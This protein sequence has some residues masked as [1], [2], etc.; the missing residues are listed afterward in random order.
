MRQT[1]GV[2]HYHQEGDVKKGDGPAP[3]PD[4]A[5]RLG[6]PERGILANSDHIAFVCVRAESTTNN[7]GE[8]EAC[9]AVVKQMNKHGAAYHP[10]TQHREQNSNIDCK[11][12]SIESGRELH[13]QVVRAM[14]DQEFWKYLGQH[15]GA[16][17]Y[18]TLDEISDD[19]W[20]AISAKAQ[21]TPSADRKTLTLVL[22]AHD[23]PAHCCDRTVERFQQRYLEAALQVGFGSIWVSDGVGINVRGLAG[24]M[25]GW[26][27]K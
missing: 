16:Q 3:L 23:L 27:A 15:K 11:A 6:N 18:R 25:S 24:Q 13:F 12:R 4:S 22:D 9:G 1:F 2:E 5:P 7:D 20:D 14:R 21:K 19:L 10:P 8:L 26:F 17:V